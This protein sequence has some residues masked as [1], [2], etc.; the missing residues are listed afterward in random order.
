MTA[1]EI[2]AIAVKIYDLLNPIWKDTD[3]VRVSK[4]EC[5]DIVRM[6]LASVPQPTLAKRDEPQPTT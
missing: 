3:V 1:D 2:D 4:Q 5:I 6:V